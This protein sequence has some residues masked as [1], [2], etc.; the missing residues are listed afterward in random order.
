[1]VVRCRWRVACDL[2]SRWCRIARPPQG[3]QMEQQVSTLS[4]LASLSSP[5]MAPALAWSARQASSR[6]ARQ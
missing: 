5:A 3:E 1:M 4:L 2:C 6:E